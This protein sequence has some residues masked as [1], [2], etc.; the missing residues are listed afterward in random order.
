MARSSKGRTAVGA[1][2]FIN[3]KLDALSA[4][5]AREIAS[6]RARAGL[7]P[8]EGAK[9]GPGDV[10]RPSRAGVPLGDLRVLDVKEGGHALVYIVEERRTGRWY[11]LKTCQ[12]WCLES[13]S[14]MRR[15]RR[16]AETLIRL[17]K[18]P[19]VARAHA[20]F[21]MH[22]R[23]F[24]LLEYAAR[25]D[26]WRKVIRGPLPV[27]QALRYAVQFCRGM[28]HA[29]EVIPGF[30]HRDVKPPNCLVAAADVL[31]IADF[32]H[33]KLGEALDRESKDAE[34]DEPGRPPDNG[35]GH[36]RRWGY[37]TPPYMAPEQFDPATPADA[38]ADIYSFGVMLF[39][40]LTKRRPFGGDEYKECEPLH[41]SAAPPDPA[42][43]NPKVPRALSSLTLKCLAKEPAERYADFKTLETELDRILRAEFR[44]RLPQA[45]PETVSV[46]ELC[47]RGASLA[48]LGRGDEALECFER[49]LS[50]R[51]RWAR[52]FER[53]GAAL[54][55]LARLD[56]ALACFERAL[57]L[58]PQMG[59]AWAGK[60]KA[61]DAT[62][63]VEEALACFDRA[64]S[65]DPALAY[66]WNDKGRCL[67]NSKRWAEA[68]E[69]FDRGRALDPR[70]AESYN[71][72]GL[73]NAPPG[74]R[75]RAEDLVDTINA[76][77][78]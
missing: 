54:V 64:L 57:A 16:E 70:L 76:A 65:L 49:V 12:D 27:R 39:E 9:Y 10:I 29:Q 67:M 56:E 72:P 41:R 34:E 73:S 47:D 51:P 46:E 36:V 19:N 30:V 68:A 2:N 55:G 6:A 5:A 32:G 61:L 59:F 18:H 17:G 63:R 53:K 25:D 22:D 28:A 31:K 37:G 50:A 3:R 60:G 13:R 77:V 78:K 14:A 20:V 24:I 48:A 43:L 4:W 58:D 74:R 71:S 11:A 66:V 52:A 75:E 33:V 62:G 40:M 26:L 15:F 69:C 7:E 1:V 23:L 44:T 45:G 8:P 42:T 38:R 21:R 35:D